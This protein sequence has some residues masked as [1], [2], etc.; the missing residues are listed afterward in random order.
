MTT[1]SGSCHCGTV[2]YEVTASLEKL[3]SCNCSM[4]ARTGTLLEFVPEEKFKLL[5]GEDSL[6]DYK[7]NKH[8]IHHVFCNKCGVKSFARGT[9]PDGKPMVAINARCLEG[10][11]PDKLP[12]VHYDGKSL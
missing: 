8:V 3:I 7:F 2:R 11:D 5:S 4:C 1:Y 9:G 12:I 6:T 10:V